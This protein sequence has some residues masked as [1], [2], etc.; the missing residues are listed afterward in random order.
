MS[1]RSDHIPKARCSAALTRSPSWI[2]STRATRFPRFVSVTVSHRAIA[3]SI[4]LGFRRMSR[5]VAFIDSP[6]LCMHTYSMHF[7]RCRVNLPNTAA[8]VP[9]CPRL[10]SLARP[11][12]A[13]FSRNKGKTAE[14]IV[15]RRQQYVNNAQEPLF[16]KGDQAARRL[17]ARP[18]SQRSPEFSAFPP[19][20]EL[21]LARTR[22]YTDPVD[23]VVG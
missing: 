2:G 15:N 18:M 10:A 23:R 20:R 22:R 12:T 9:R 7:E 19:R 1:D 3:S 6:P 5:I 14:F 21:L 17:R 4:F 13:P 16:R 8:G 11:A